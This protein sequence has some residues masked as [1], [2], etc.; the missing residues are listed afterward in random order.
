MSLNKLIK[1]DTLLYRGTNDYTNYTRTNRPV[2]FLFGENGKNI[3]TSAYTKFIGSQV[4]DFY[5]SA[6][7]RLL[8]MGNPK[9]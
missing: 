3:A 1:K 5:T 2:F 7:L 6:N 4:Y 9:N 8:D